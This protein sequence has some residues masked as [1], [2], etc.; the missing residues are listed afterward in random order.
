MA[1]QNRDDANTML[2]LQWGLPGAGG[3]PG[4]EG[5]LSEVR[6]VDANPAPARAP[7]SIRTGG[8]SATKIKE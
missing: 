5:T 2:E 3:Q 1:M 7:K 6:P 4:Q 8:A